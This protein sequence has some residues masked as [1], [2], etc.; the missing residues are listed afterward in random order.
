MRSLKQ[1]MMVI[2]MNAQKR[3]VPGRIDPSF[4]RALSILIS[5]RIVIALA[6]FFAATFMPQKNDS[7]W[8]VNSSWYR[9]LLRYDSGWYLR[10]IGQGYS[11]NGNNLEMQPVVFYPLYPVL[12]KTITKLLRVN[13]PVAALLVSNLSLLGAALLLFKLI[14]DDYG[15][16]TAFL[17]LAF[18]SFFPTAIFFSAGYTESLALLI[19]VGFFLLLKRRRFFLAATCAGL[20]CATRSTGLV[21]LLPLLWEIWRA[22][23]NEKR[24]LLFTN[25]VCLIIATSGLWLYML[26]LA[27]AFRSP[28]ALL[29][30]TRAW[31]QANPASG[32]LGLIGS[33]AL[34]QA[35]TLQPFWQL[36]EIFSAGPNPNTLD[37]WFFLLFLLL[38]VIFRKRVPVA[39]TLYTLGVLLLPYITVSGSVGFQSFSRYIL[40]AFPVFVVIGQSCQKRVWLGLNLVGLE[41]AL[42]FMYSAMF[43]QWYW[44]G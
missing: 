12:S 19:I 10:I 16:E 33:G 39:F 32:S 26:Y 1:I 20:A 25:A 43:A 30:G 21:L 31:Q 40:L 3:K 27:A 5:S 28:F 2:G 36:E 11:Y 7:L 38:I 15:E 35:L 23:T 6:M 34:F 22:Y 14:K 44:I 29:S 42:L 4:A 24:R 17:A 8:N 9:F 41:A 18:I 13:A 37:P